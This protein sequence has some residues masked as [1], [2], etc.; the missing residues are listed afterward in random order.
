MLLSWLVQQGAL[1][2][3][4]CHKR[5][6][7]RASVR[8]THSCRSRSTKNSHDTQMC[9]QSRRCHYQHISTQKHCAN[10][11]ITAL[12][13]PYSTKIQARRKIADPLLWARSI[14]PYPQE[15]CGLSLLCMKTG[16]LCSSAPL[17]C[18]CG[19]RSARSTQNPRIPARAA[20]GRWPPL[21]GH[22]QGRRAKWRR[23]GAAVT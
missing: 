11:P 7:A 12:P 19:S 15:S 18:Q 8:T 10:R 5:N 23:R 6:F 3:E 4:Y 20:H 17:S 22:S 16:R 14:T 9:G 21:T 13:L 2:D 1:L